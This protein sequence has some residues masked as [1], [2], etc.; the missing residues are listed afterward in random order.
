MSSSTV[1]PLSRRARV[2]TT[3]ARRSRRFLMLGGSLVATL[4]IASAFLVGS[5]AVFTSTS[6]NPSNVFTAGILTQTNSKAPGA[7]LTA[8]LMKP[9]DVK[10][11]TVVIK[12]TGDLSGDFTA[13][14]A[15]TADTAGA[16]GGS[17]F[18]VLK[19]KIEDGSTTLYNGNMKDF[20]TQALGTYAANDTHTYTF[21][22][23]FPDGGTPASNTTE[24]NA[25]QGSSTTVSFT[26]TAVQH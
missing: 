12:N 3:R 17:L 4:I 11:G 21:T 25:Y 23:T 14:M 24:D 7:I 15:K 2:R 10:T 20:T 9:G 18:N 1:Q 6:A 13:T 26:W 16:N 8:S 19:L 22:V 5:G